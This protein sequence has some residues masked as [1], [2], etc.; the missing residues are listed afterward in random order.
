VSFDL[1]TTTSER[2]LRAVESGT[3]PIVAELVP[4]DA[5]VTERLGAALGVP[6]E[7][8]AERRWQDL[9]QEIATLDQK[10][11]DLE[12]SLGQVEDELATTLLDAWPFIDDPFHP[13]FE[14]VFQRDEA[15]IGETILRSRTALER[16]SLRA[17]LERAYD[18]FDR[19]VVREARVL[20][21]LRAYETLHKAAALHRRGGAAARTYEQLLQCERAVVGVTTAPR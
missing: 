7:A 14:A 5:A 15:A 10:L 16:K 20:R 4:E 3:A 12:Q 18:A 9:D 17:T 1:P 2:W 6:T 21:V 8:D 11:Q 13:Q 19:L